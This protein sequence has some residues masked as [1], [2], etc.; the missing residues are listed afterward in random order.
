MAKIL[1]IV[2]RAPDDLDWKGAAAWKTILSLC[3]SQHE[4]RV[5]TPLDP[6][7]IEWSHP[8]LTITRPVKSWA[9]TELPKFIQ[10]VFLFNPDVIHTF[11]LKPKARFAALSLWPWA[12]GLGKLLPRTKRWSTLF[13]AEDLSRDD[14]SYAWHAQGHGITVASLG[15]R[16]RLREIFSGRIEALPLDLDIPHSQD[17]IDWRPTGPFAL[18]PAAVA[19]WAEPTRGLEKLRA[20]LLARRDLQ[21]VIVGGWGSLGATE[22][23][24]GWVTL[25]PVMAQ[26]RM[27]ERLNLG[28]VM[29]HAKRAE[30]IWL[31]ALAPDSWPALVGRRLQPDEDAP[32]ASAS[33]N[34]LSRL[35]AQS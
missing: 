3:E 26:V 13:D 33:A 17:L 6:E 30:F 2:D 7:T 34:F 29:A 18:V 9:A 35:Y 27:V 19:D 8:R 28:Q 14:A 12:T 5:L 16:D 20:M 24:Q 15:A 32:E 1:A 21:A 4:V 31:D 25:S 11:A 10:A 23:R 22:K